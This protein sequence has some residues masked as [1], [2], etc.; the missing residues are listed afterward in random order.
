MAEYTRT[1]RDWPATNAPVEA[2]TLQAAYDTKLFGKDT[3]FS[4]V[5]G[6]GRQGNSGDEFKK[7]HQFILGS[8]IWVT[9][10]FAVSAEYV[11]NKGFVP[12]IMI[13][14]ASIADVET[15]TLILSGKVFF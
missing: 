7:L 12:L 10:N 14:R 6:L 15:H 3:R 13:S 11:Y 1:G 4:A 9:R 8:E 2:L 5:Y